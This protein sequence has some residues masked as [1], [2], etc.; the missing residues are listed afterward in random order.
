MKRCESSSF[1]DLTICSNMVTITNGAFIRG[2]LGMTWTVIIVAM[3]S[4]DGQLCAL[5]ECLGITCVAGV[6]V[7]TE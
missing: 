3:S 7:E 1:S 2:S 4:L 5:R 6:G